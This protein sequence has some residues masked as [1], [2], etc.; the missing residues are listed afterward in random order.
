[1]QRVK[2]QIHQ[3]I[4]KDTVVFTANYTFTVSIYSKYIID[5]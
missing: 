3:I 4:L 1:V 2:I 5:E